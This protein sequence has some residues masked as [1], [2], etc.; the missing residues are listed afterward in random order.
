MRLTLFLLI[1]I[2]GMYLV[3]AVRYAT[4]TPDWQ[5]PDEPAHYNYI[6]QLE[7]GAIPVIRMGD[8]DTEYQNT[9]T[10]T[11]FN[12]IHLNEL[13]RIQY[14]D[15]QPP[16]Y[17]ILATPIFAASDGNLT[18]L[19][20]FSVFIGLGVILASFAVLYRLFPEMPLLAL[21]VAAFIAF[22]PQHL[23]FLSGVNNDPLAGL[24]VGLILLRVVTYLQKPTV[25]KQDAILLGVLV[26]LA[27]LTKVTVYFLAGVV[28]VAIL[29]RGWREKWSRPV[30]IQQ[31]GL[32]LLPAL[33]MGGV[34]WGRN[35]SVYGG[36]DF[37]GLQ[38]HDEVAAGQ[39]QTADYIERDLNGN[40]TQYYKNYAYTTFHSFWGQFGW[41]A[42][43]MPTRIY[44]ILLGGVLFCLMGFGLFAL[45]NYRHWQRPQKEML[46][47]LMLTLGLVGAAYL[48]Y[49]RQ[50]VQ[51]QGRYLY[52]ALIPMGFLLAGGL[53]GWAHLLPAKSYTR[54]IPVL[55]ML[56]LA[57]LAWYALGTYITP[58]LPAWE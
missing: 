20:L 11:G 39:L 47:L 2:V 12:P 6:R 26:G 22:L 52:P 13:D 29:L 32:F 1:L 31:I 15:H 44:R 41:M 38:R 30:A 49:N 37:L 14:E 28:G 25:Q 24:M 43:P 33:V 7:D 57:W 3:L 21:G 17:Y 18:T 10:S 27:C 9:L 4:E 35:L 54:W 34:W 50:F 19:R 36:T 55:V 42:I 16:L 56:L 58:N 45:Q 40:R 48:L 5:V 46:F 23:S 53:S 8:W 51:F